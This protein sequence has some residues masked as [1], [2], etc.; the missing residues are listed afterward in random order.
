MLSFFGW[1][2]PSHDIVFIF[3]LFFI[4][5]F[6]IFRYFFSGQNIFP[7]IFPTLLVLLDCCWFYATANCVGGFET[8]GKNSKFTKLCSFWL[9]TLLL[10]FIIPEN[11]LTLQAY[12]FFCF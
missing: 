4:F 11:V 1:I 7:L 2:C 3:G 5:L 12:C 8:Y 6:L 9:F 10:L